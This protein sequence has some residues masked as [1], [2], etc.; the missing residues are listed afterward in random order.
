MYGSD[1]RT[2][3]RDWKSCIMKELYGAESEDEIRGLE[4]MWN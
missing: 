3:T 2:L 1:V 4:T